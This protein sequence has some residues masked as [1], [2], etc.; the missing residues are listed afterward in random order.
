MNKELEDELKRIS[1]KEISNDD[2]SHDFSHALRVLK[3]SKKLQ[4]EEG[5]NLDIIVPASLFHDI[6]VFPKDSEDSKN[7]SYE[8]AKKARR[9]LESVN[10]YPKDKISLVET[11]IKNCSFSKSV[12]PES[13]EEKILN[14]ADGLEAVGAIAIMRTFASSGVMKRKFYSEI[15]PFCKERQQDDKSFALDLFYSRLLKINE[16]LNTETARKIAEKRIQFLYKF[17]EELN[18]EITD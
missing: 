9:I 2:P 14:D 7:S 10:D 3:N 11:A 1:K 13:I 16:R 5:G 17:L 18:S 12:K 8:S 4:I 15:D 6:I